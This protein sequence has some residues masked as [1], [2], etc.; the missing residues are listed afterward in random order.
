MLCL[1]RFKSNIGYNVLKLVD[2]QIGPIILRMYPGSTNQNS[3][4]EVLFILDH[5]I[6]LREKFTED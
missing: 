5:D 6:E 1:P 3:Y 2:N 4:D